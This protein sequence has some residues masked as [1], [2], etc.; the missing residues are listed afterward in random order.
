MRA[1]VRLVSM[2]GSTRRNL[3][4]AQVS[5]GQWAAATTREATLP[6]KSLAKPVRPWV[7][8]TMRSAFLDLD[9]RTICSC[10]TPSSTTVVAL[11]PAAR[12][13]AWRAA[14]FF[15]AYLRAEASRSSYRLGGMYPSPAM[16][17]GGASTC[18]TNN[19]AL[20]DLAKAMARLNAAPEALEKSVGWRMRRC[21]LMNALLGR[22]GRWVAGTQRI[23]R[24]PP[25]SK[26]VTSRGGSATAGRRAGAVREPIARLPGR[27]EGRC[28]ER[29]RRGVARP[30][31]GG[32]GYRGAHPQELAEKIVELHRD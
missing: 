20:S 8:M 29:Q 14:S 30:E 25:A 5:T 3:P 27:V 23:A 31:S 18:A 2:R 15:S 32:H 22:N 17:M 24:P 26:T 28:G 19:C 1:S 21:L 9:A 13:L 12:A 7:P 16:G 6:R 10:A 11:T 4:A